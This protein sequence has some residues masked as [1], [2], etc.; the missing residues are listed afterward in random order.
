MS[1]G[2]VVQQMLTPAV[3]HRQDTAAVTALDLPVGLHGQAQ[4]AAGLAFEQ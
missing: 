4:P 3:Q 1:E 2:C